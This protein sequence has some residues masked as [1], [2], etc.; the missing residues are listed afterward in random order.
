VPRSMSSRVAAEDSAGGKPLNP[1][2]S[3][4]LVAVVAIP[5]VLGLVWLGGW[6][7][8]FLAA[9]AAAFALHEY[10][11]LTRP[12]R[13][14]VLAGFG[15]ALA[16][17]LGVELG[18]VVWMT[19]G[20]LATL[21][22]AF[23]VQGLTGTRSS[24]SAA[25]GSTVL[26][27][28]WIALGLCHIL[29]LREIEDHGRLAAYTLLITVWAADTAAYFSGRLF[30]RHKL[31]PTLSPGKTWE[32]FVA[33]SA[34]GIFAS[35]ICLY[36]TGF[37]DGW[38]SLVLGAVIVVAAALG[39]LFESSIKRDAGVKDSGRLLGGHGGM[40]DRLDALLF[41]GAAAFYAILALDTGP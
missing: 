17:L 36:R 30:G 25:I 13:P 8:W 37:V 10:F 9:V 16:A 29:L 6:W 4:V 3:R 21:V 41:A 5:A 15:G 35:F 33:G 27:V 32:G 34:A 2:V 11:N 38:R 40:L 12:L 14:L 19:G 39:D 28:A 24:P 1:F 20:F 31:A 23:V 7:L 22:L 18:D 26:G